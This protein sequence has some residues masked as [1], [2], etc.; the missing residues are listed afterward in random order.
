[1]DRA[2]AQQSWYCLTVVLEGVS[3]ERR[4][5]V[6]KALNAAGVGTSIYYPQPVPR[7]TYYRNKY[8]SDL[9]LYPNATRISDQSIALPVGPH[10]LEGDIAYI[11][12]AFERILK[13]KQ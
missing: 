9:S 12:A 8:N 1:V 7:L 6:V 3:A 5:A 2:D 10:L 4:N 13:E 11:A